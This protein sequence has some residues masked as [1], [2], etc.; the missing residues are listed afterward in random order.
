MIRRLAFLLALGA[1]AAAAQPLTV[2]NSANF[3]EF[4]PL[5]PGSLA[6]AFLD[7][8]IDASTPVEAITVRVDGR[9]ADILGVALRQINFRVPP[10]IEAGLRPRAVPVAVEMRGDVLAERTVAVRDASPAIFLD[11]AG[12]AE[13]PAVALNA[14]GMRNGNLFP[15]A[16]GEVLELFLT[17]HGVRLISPI[18][19]FPPQSAV[20]PTVYFR[21]FPGETLASQL[22]EP[23]LWRI[24]VRVPELETRGPTPVVVSFD[25]L[26]SNTASVWLE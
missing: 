12:R 21:T 17:G 9:R 2:V 19:I 4:R 22:I 24:R 18:E 5:A 8:P 6:T 23:G 1:A 15:A 16:S 20:T 25:G 14:D 11:D 26:Q 10:E 7:A 3:E 13:R